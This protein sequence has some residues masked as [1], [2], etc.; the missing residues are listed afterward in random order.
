MFDWF[1]HNLTKCPVKYRIL[2]I[3]SYSA[4]DSIYQKNPLKCPHKPLSNLLS[5][6]LYTSLKW[7]TIYPINYQYIIQASTSLPESAF[8][9]APSALVQTSIHYRLDP[10][11]SFKAGHPA[12]SFVSH[13]TRPSCCQQRILSEL[14]ICLCHLLKTLLNILVHSHSPSQIF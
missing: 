1:S 12:L 14:Q 10:C 9:L 5:F 2:I 3:E 6:F 8:I 13:Q 11:N 7:H 4:S